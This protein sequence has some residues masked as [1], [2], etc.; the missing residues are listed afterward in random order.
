M[1][2]LEMQTENENLVGRC[3]RRPHNW[4]TGYFTSLIGREIVR[5]QKW[6][7]HLH[8]LQKLFFVIVKYANLCHSRRRRRRGLLKLP[9]KIFKVAVVFVGWKSRPLWTIQ[10]YL[11]AI[12]LFKREK[13]TT[14][15]ERMKHNRAHQSYN[16]IDTRT[17]T[18]REVNV[19]LKFVWCRYQLPSTLNKDDAIA[20]SLI[21]GPSRRLAPVIKCRRFLSFFQR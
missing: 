15:L 3:S 4:K 6:K 2:G 5:I 16:W 7:T 21:P 18:R 14:K 20:F 17:R 10:V 13:K 11:R 9:T 8:S 19:L 1:S 12:C